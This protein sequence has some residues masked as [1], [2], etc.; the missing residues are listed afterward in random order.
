MDLTGQDK[1]PRWTETARN[2]DSQ[3]KE[4]AFGS[5]LTKCV[6]KPFL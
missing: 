2:E 6:K 1:E 4:S 5:K 3:E